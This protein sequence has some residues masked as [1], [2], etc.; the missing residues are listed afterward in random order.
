M[1]GFIGAGLKTNPPLLWL[2]TA[3]AGEGAARLV[4]GSSEALALPGS[5]GTA[6]AAVATEV[7]GKNEGLERLAPEATCTGLANINCELGKL[8][9]GF[10]VGLGAG[11]AVGAFGVAET[12]LTP[13]VNPTDFPFVVEVAVA[14]AS[15][16]TEDI[17]EGPKVNVFAETTCCTA[18]ADVFTVNGKPEDIFLVSS[19]DPN[20]SVVGVGAG[21]FF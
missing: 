20:L 21:A 6:G 19:G 17:V 18:G 5:A 3:A 16:A 14:W 10:T 15:E 7:T 11:A 12:V 9:A 2:E 4:T 8:N 1:K 13:K